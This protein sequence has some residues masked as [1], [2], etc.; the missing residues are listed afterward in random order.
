MIL[1]AITPASRELTV[2][3]ARPRPSPR[4]ASNI[5]QIYEGGE[6]RASTFFRWNCGWRHAGAKDP[7]QAD[8]IA[9][10]AQLC[11]QLAIAME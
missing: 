5:V 11:K 4:A 8:A 6:S 1:A 7:R 10:A 3:V 9:E 2:F